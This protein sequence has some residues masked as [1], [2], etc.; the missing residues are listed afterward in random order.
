MLIALSTTYLRQTVASV[1]DQTYDNFELVLCDDGPRGGAEAVLQT[2]AAHPRFDRIRYFPNAER[3]GDARNYVACFKQARGAYIKF[4]N[5]DDTL[6]PRCLEVMACCLRAHPDVT[7]VT[8]H[9]QIIDH[10]D[11]LQ[12]E[13]SYTKR[14]IGRSAIVG[15]RSALA[16]MLGYRLNFIGEPSTVMFRKS[17]LEGRSRRT[18]GRLRGPTSTATAT[19]AS[20]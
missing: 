16:R 14:P 9:R 11:R 4:L 13:A 7:L 1:L 12:S 5:D 18:S 15:A 17:E 2:F 6:A 8:S 10:D 19:S 3:Q 20:G